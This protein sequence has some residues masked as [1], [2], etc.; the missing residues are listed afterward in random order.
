MKISII[1]FSRKGWQLGTQLSDQLREKGEDVKSWVKSRYVEGAME[2]SL[3][4]WTKQRFSDSDALIFIGA[5]GI[6]VRAVAPWIKSKGSDPAVLVIDEGGNFVISLLSGHLGGANRLA[7]AVSQMINGIP[8]ITTGTDVRQ[9]WAVDLF[10]KENSCTIDDLKKIKWISAAL[11]AGERVDFFS[12]V[13]Y[14][15]EVPEGISPW[16]EGKEKRQIGIALSPFHRHGTLFCHTLQLL[17]RCVSLGIG[18]K[19]GTDAER[20]RETVEEALQRAD[21]DKRSICAVG[22]IELKQDEAGLL[23][24]CR[25]LGLE[26]RFYSAEALREV[27][28]EFQHSAFVEQVTGVDNVCERS[29]MLAAAEAEGEGEIEL[30]S[31]KYGKNGVTVAI[32]I[33]KRSVKFE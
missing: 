25:E 16:E 1:S 4:A 22:T 17:P 29:A 5:S 2:E 31:E 32:G 26:P 20:I 6:A 8:V 23:A 10:A 12:L 3:E 15:G 11:L 33:K 13:P 19:R 9:R 14:Q 7:L 28:G 21:I 18:C 27:P 24:F 30:L